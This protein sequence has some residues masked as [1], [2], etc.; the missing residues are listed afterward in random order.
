MKKTKIFAALTAAVL[1]AANSAVPASDF[2]T[3]AEKVNGAEST[4]YETCTVRISVVDI[5]TG[6]NVD[7]VEVTLIEN[8]FGTSRV[9]APWNTS[10]EPV[11]EMTDLYEGEYAIRFDNV[12]KEYV[13]SESK[14]ITF[15]N[16]IRHLFTSFFGSP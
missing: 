7:G 13:L 12:P 16:S 2:G 14:C 11:K 6:K 8:P 5:N 10:D 1:F 15:E 4:G 3:G 9:F